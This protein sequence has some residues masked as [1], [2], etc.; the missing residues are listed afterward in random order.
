MNNS[1]KYSFQLIIILITLS[2]GKSDKDQ[3][4]STE[5][6]KSTNSIGDNNIVKVSIEQFQSENMKL[7]SI[8]ELPFPS[9]IRT[10]GM[11]DVPPSSRAV[12]S[13]YVG[14]YIKNAPLLI[15]DKVKKDKLWLP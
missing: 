1:I 11:I 10:T 3:S 7:V 5:T 13:A 15:G 12:I 14:G 8:K 6:S 9:Y 2:C 4:V